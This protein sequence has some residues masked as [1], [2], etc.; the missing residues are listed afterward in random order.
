MTQLIITA[1]GPDQPGLVGQLTGHI[2][3]GGGN[4]IESRMVN[5]RGQF[6]VILMA[7]GAEQAVRKLRIS[8]VEAG[9]Q[10]GLHV[11]TTEHSNPAQ[12]VQGLPYRLKT[13]SLDQPGIMHAVTDVLRAHGVNIEDLQARQESAAFSGTPL[14]VMEMH[15][16]VP[17][18]LSVKKLRQELEQQCEKLNCDMDIEPA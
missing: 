15:M 9:E 6:A 17:A 10:M 3:A 18:N 5:L 2:T 1:I 13:Y 7:E 16:T 14:F 4:I 11:N 8:L 12:K